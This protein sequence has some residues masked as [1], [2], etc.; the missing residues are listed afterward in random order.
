MLKKSLPNEAH[1]RVVAA[2]VSAAFNAAV[3]D[4]LLARNPFKARSVQM[5]KVADASVNAWTTDQL[6][7]VQ[8]SLPARF[9]TAVELGAGCGLRQGETF[10]FSVDEADFES[11]WATVTHQLKRLRG[12]Y[13]FAPPKD[14]ETRQVPLPRAVAGALR[15]HAAAFPPITVN[16][17]W[18]T[19]DK[20]R[21]I[22]RLYFS[23]AA[24]MNVRVSH[25]N[26][27]MWKPALA[28]AGIIPEPE[29]GERYAS[30]REHG[31]HA[32]RHFYASVLLD[33]GENI[34][35][36][37]RCLGHAD[38]GF[39]LRTYTHLMPSS[40]LRTRNAVDSLYQE[41]QNHDHGPRRVT[42]RSLGSFRLV[43]S[44]TAPRRQNSIYFWPLYTGTSIPEDLWRD[45]MWLDTWV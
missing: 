10:E 29:E 41:P 1:R 16:L 21:R 37:N 12:R 24:G 27:F 9:R 32:L 25:F 3:D 20:E 35:V 17:R 8:R 36:L 30:A 19:V 14:G 28:S 39:T 15:A 2:T 42:D 33:A 38:A 34:K 7:T 23:G 11:G 45:R 6:F 40:E 13:V 31:L 5:P 22:R 26:D 44:G 4:E 18:R 43:F